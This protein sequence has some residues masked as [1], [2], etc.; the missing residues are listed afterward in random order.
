MLIC[1]IVIYIFIGILV[2]KPWKNN[3]GLFCIYI[4]WWI[5]VIFCFLWLPIVLLKLPYE[6]KENGIKAITS[7]LKKII[8]HIWLPLII[9]YKIKDMVVDRPFVQFEKNLVFRHRWNLNLFKKV[10]SVKDEI[11]YIYWGTGE[12]TV[13][14]DGSI[15][16]ECRM[17]QRLI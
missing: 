15:L 14:S 11:G 16:I 9:Y 4:P 3:G 10:Q 8:L 1:G 12:E 17:C 7:P 5:M 6:I 2:I 13:L